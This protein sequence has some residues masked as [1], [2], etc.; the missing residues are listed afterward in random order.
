MRRDFIKIA[1]SRT[2]NQF[3]CGAASGL[4]PGAR[5]ES[6]FFHAAGGRSRRST[7]ESIFFKRKHRQ[8]TGEQKIIYPAGDEMATH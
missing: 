4:R 2:K 6:F 8:L 5:R 7:R 3:S 1:S